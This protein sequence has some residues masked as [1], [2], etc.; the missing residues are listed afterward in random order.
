MLVFSIAVIRFQWRECCLC[1]LK[2][3]GLACF[4]LLSYAL[5]SFAVSWFDALC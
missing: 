2:L 4:L 1:N 5:S 3:L